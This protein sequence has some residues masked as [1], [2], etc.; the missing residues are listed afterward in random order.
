MHQTVSELV[1]WHISC[2]TFLY[3]HKNNCQKTRGKILGSLLGAAAAAALFGVLS[4][5]TLP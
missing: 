5:G 2:S 4:Q 3:L 1:N